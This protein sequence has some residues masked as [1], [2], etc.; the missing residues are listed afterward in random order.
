MTAFLME[1]LSPWGRW[2]GKGVGSG[3]LFRDSSA[4]AGEMED[5][6]A[7]RS[8]DETLSLRDGLCYR[9]RRKIL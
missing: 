7:R 2:R 5:A 9:E 8:L 1:V 6:A 3:C 4:K